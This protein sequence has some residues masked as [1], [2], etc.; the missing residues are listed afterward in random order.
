MQIAADTVVSIDYTLTDP[1]GQVLDSSQGREPLVY[2]HG[3]GNI[4]QIG[5]AH[6]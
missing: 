4:I 3:H 1:K 6:V 2:L 5:R